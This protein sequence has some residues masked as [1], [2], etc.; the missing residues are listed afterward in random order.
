MLRPVCGEFPL[1][2]SYWESIPADCRRRMF[3]F[4]SVVEE[5]RA[6]YGA[7]PQPADLDDSPRLALEDII[8]LTLLNSREYQAAKE[9]LYR[10][11]LALMLA[12][13]DYELKPTAG[14]N[15]TA[16]NYTH[17]RSDGITVDRWTIGPTAFGVDKVLYTGGDI[18][19]RFANEVVLTF[20]GPRGFAT[21]VSSDL[22]FEFFQTIFQWDGELEGLTQAERDL[23][24][25]ARDFA[26][27]RK[28]LFV[29]QASRYYNLILDFRRVEIDSQNYFTLVREFDQRAVEYR[30]GFTSRIDLDQIE[31][32]VI[33]G[34]RNLL[35]TCTSLEN[36]LDDLKLRIGLPT[37]QLIN[38][39][40]SELDM[41]TSRD[42]LSVNAELIGVSGLDSQP[43]C[44]PRLRNAPRS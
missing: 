11:S 43:K 31:Q 36:S 18:L 10:V 33:N 28:D 26:R 12:R 42:E 3:E 5:Y 4:E 13:F 9:T 16:T 20:N 17:N 19:A 14:G 40:L 35:N 41:L 1:T 25:A 34:R 30:G 39:D 24:Y 44:N 22:F 2:R 7:E 27:F 21:D 23:V 8:A 37:E 38:L 32:Q 15:R 6:T 29:Q